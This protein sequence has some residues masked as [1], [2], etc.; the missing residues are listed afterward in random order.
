MTVSFSRT[1]CFAYLLSACLLIPTTTK[2]ASD[3]IGDAARA[4]GRGIE[5]LFG[6]HD[7][8]EINAIKP[9]IT[10]PAGTGAVGHTR[11]YL[12]KMNCSAAPNTANLI[13]EGLGI[14]QE[15]FVAHSLWFSSSAGDASVPANPV[16]LVNAFSF[17]KDS[18]GTINDFD[19]QTC[20]D[21]FLLSGE[22][23]VLTVSFLLA[24]TKTT[25]GVVKAFSSATKI[26]TGIVPLFLGGP[27]ATTI[28]GAAKAAGDTADP[29]KDIVEAFNKSP[30][31]AVV[32]VRLKATPDPNRPIVVHTAYSDVKITVTP[33]NDLTRQITSDEN[34][35]TSFKKVFSAATAPFQT[36]LT[37]ATVGDHCGG[38]A[39]TLADNYKFSKKDQAFL[40]G[41]FGT[42]AS[43]GDVDLRLSCIGA[44]D[45]AQTVVTEQFDYNKSSG[46]FRGI[47]QRDIDNHE[48][49]EFGTKLNST[50][51]GVY[52]E[53]L[54][55]LLPAYAQADAQSKASATSAVLVW[56][57]AS[58][59]LVEDPTTEFSAATDS[60]MTADAFLGK[61]TN[62]YK[63][64]GCFILD[65]TINIGPYDAIMLAMPLTPEKGDTFEPEE[66]MGMHIMLA[67]SG[68]QDPPARLLKIG[69]TKDT[70]AILEA[71]KKF[72][73][74]CYKAKIDIKP[75]PQ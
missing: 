1:T 50:A 60:S 47:Q 55:N 17:A 63:R 65:A 66:L 56:I 74:K 32:S 57:N 3:P 71:A 7:T 41:Y 23:D 69:F 16:K 58:N 45:I 6:V 5:R 33:V 39:R 52:L 13:S 42:S 18:S 54:S 38:F 19:N 70:L 35:Y 14:K 11:F 49:I 9:K 34:L 59:V 21:T 20:S 72:N 24:D 67:G 15:T 43:P 75:P 28:T 12:V 73:G 46:A 40:I 25:S 31:K 51:A 36:G 61:L 22:N 29:I 64:Y 53:K 37:K 48:W 4:I 26:M 44:R 10:F 62:R 68:S 27:L 2:A 30:R 8:P